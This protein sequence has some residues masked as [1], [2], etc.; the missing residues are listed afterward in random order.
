MGETGPDNLSFIPHV[1]RLHDFEISVQF[2]RGRHA[3][4]RLSG[5]LDMCSVDLF[6]AVL[7]HH[8]VAG[9]RF[10]RLD[11][12]DLTFVDCAGLRGV[13]EAQNKLLARHGGLVLTKV[14]RRTARLL[15]I[16][17]L[18]TVLRIAPEP[19]ISGPAAVT[20]I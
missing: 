5:E 8:I 12:G 4:L 11:L 19:A 15:Q 1:A 17:E 20:A 3:T 18:D 16:T 6:A 7:Q 2:S 14:S 9:R 10:F 13:V